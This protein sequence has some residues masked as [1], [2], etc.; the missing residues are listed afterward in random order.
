MFL[1]DWTSLSVQISTIL[2][3]LPAEMGEFVN[4]ISQTN[5]ANF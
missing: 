3:T 4:K 5:V 1:V 2:S